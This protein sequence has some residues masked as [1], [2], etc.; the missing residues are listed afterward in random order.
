MD[1]VRP[2]VLSLGFQSIVQC[3][4]QLYEWPRGG[5]GGFVSVGGWRRGGGGMGL[6]EFTGG[7]GGPCVCG[8]PPPSSPSKVHVDLRIS[9]THK[10]MSLQTE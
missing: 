9:N 7:A 5:G 10:Q 8:G 6:V 1:C 4:V 2:H 3:T